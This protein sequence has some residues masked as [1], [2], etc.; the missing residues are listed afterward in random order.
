MTP[1]QHAGF[2]RPTG[3]PLSA[4]HLVRQNRLLWFF[5]AALAA[6]FLASIFVLNPTLD[7]E[8]RVFSWPQLQL[9]FA[10]TPQRG[11]AVLA[12]WGDGAAERY[13]RVIWIDILFALSY[14]PFFFLLIRRLGGG[15]AWALV[16]LLEM[17]TNLVE[18]SL[19]IYWVVAHSP[20]NPLFAAFLVHSIV[21]TIKWCVL[22][23]VYLLHS[24][25]LLRRALMARLIANA[26][27][28]PFPGEAGGR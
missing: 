11:D 25:I 27:F 6:T 17:G 12:R 5:F 18:T 21:A 28:V 4:N 3:V 20:A 8:S 13:L 16:P 19:E 23:P 1:L 14:G 22:V 7:P 10:Y 26:Q 15:A 2:S 9:Q 24:A